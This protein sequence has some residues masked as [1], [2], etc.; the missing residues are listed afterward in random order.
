M[1]DIQQDPAV[2]KLIEYAKEKKNLSYEEL[3][4]FLP[5]SIANT[6]KIEQVLALLEEN[7]IQLLVDDD[8]AAGEEPEAAEPRKTAGE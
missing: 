8:A 4:D 1:S 2:Q 6:D 3:S 5:D 7:S